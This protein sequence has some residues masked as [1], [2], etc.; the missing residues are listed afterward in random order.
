MY[1][2]TPSL[3][4]LLL[5]SFEDCHNMTEAGK[6]CECQVGPRAVGQGQA[7]PLMSL[8]LEHKRLESCKLSRQGEQAGGKQPRHLGHKASQEPR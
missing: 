5:A 4:Q 2:P 1:P 3:L 6:E 8:A 7:R